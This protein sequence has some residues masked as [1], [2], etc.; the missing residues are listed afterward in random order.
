[1]EHTA[2][3][4]S[5]NRVSRFAVLIADFCNKIGTFRKCRNAATSPLLGLNRTLGRLRWMSDSDPLRSSA[6]VGQCIAAARFRTIQV[7][8]KDRAEL[9][10]DTR[11]HQTAIP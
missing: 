3:C 6:L 11:F 4:A 9:L 5:K 2:T 7:H 1:M 10:G 8:P